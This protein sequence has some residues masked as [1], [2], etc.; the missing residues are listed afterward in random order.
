M[1]QFENTSKGEDTYWVAGTAQGVRITIRHNCRNKAEWLKEFS[2]CRMGTCGYPTAEYQKIDEVEIQEPDE[3][4]LEF[5]LT[6]Q[7]GETFDLEELRRCLS[8]QQA[9]FA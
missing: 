3:M 4:T 2:R 8:Q 6:V 1:H 9:R 5:Q 7:D